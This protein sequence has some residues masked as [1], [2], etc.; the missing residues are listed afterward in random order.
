MKKLIA[1][2][3]G[4]F[5]SLFLFLL[6]SYVSIFMADILKFP[7]PILVVLNSLLVLY[8]LYLVFKLIFKFSKDESIKLSV[9]S[10][11]FSIV[12]FMGW[13]IS[14]FSNAPNYW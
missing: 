8:L 10:F 5:G 6:F 12:I 11:V 2:I 4:F 14:T 3:T 9:L 7:M 13:C 1:L